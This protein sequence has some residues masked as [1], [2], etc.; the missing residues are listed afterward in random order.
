MDSIARRQRG[1]APYPDPEAE[2]RRRVLAALV[3]GHGPDTFPTRARAR[4]LAE[5]G[6]EQQRTSATQR[7]QGMPSI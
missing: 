5:G 1:A 6:R 4:R 7:T 2:A 3:V